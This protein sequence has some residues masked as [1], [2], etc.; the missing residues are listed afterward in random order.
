[1]QKTTIMITTPKGLEKCLMEEVKALG[2]PLKWAGT[3]GV[4]TVGTLFDAM[5]LN[6]HLR[7]GHRV[8]LLLKTF[9]C[10]NSDELYK[11]VVE[12]PWETMVPA[13]GYLSVV[14]NVVNDTVTDTRFP[15]L[16]CKDA[17]C[18]RINKKK[19]RQPDAGPEH[20]GVV[21]N[22]FWRGD[23]C[24][25][26]LDTSGEPLSKRGYRTLPMAAPMQETLAAGIIKTCNWGGEGN[27]VNP[28][29]GSGTIAIEAALVASNRAPG[30]TRKSFG[31][32]H[33]LMYERA[34]W[35]K[36]VDKARSEIVLSP[37]CCIVGTNIDPKA[38]KAA[39]MNAEAAGV[40]R[41]ISFKVADFSETEVAAGG[42]V[43]VLNPEFGIRLG[44][45]KKLVEMYRS[46]G[47][48]LKQK[49]RG[50]RG[51]VFTAEPALA[52]QVG[53]KAKRHYNFFSGKI[54]CRLYE[55]D[56]F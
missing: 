55:Y 2:L 19:G 35:Q 23:Q 6:L 17:V 31:F 21:I 13:D 38:V 27:F 33:T 44:K 14:S 45:D 24:E 36:L 46:I 37:E 32:M 48:F 18:D 41:L 47:S 16:R 40:G 10:R 3:A 43:V 53:L 29:S 42:G 5:K 20:T 25:I 49:C 51:Y 7:T 15:S 34:E 39:R 22:L 56:L 11:T 54:E 52:G 1:M 8:L 30:L 9:V 4:K 12:M 28:M 50:Y 26:Y